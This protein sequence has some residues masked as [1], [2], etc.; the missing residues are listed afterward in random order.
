MKGIEKVSK[1]VLELEEEN[2]VL[3][4]NAGIEKHLISKNLYKYNIG[5]DEEGYVLAMD[6][7]E[8]LKLAG[9]E[10]RLKLIIENHD[11]LELINS[12]SVITYLLPY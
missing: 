7:E 9:E 6:D 10:A 5:D 8:A 4:S 12:G 2:A 3:K 11:L 1:L